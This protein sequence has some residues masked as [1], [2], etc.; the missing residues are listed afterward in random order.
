[1]TRSPYFAEHI[2]RLVRERYGADGLMKRGLHVETT[3]LPLV[4]GIAYENVDFSTRKQDRRQG[5]RGPE[6]HL[7]GAARDTFLERQ[8]R[9]YGE[10]RIAP[11]TRQLAIVDSVDAARA[12]VRVAGNVYTIPLRNMDWAAKWSKNDST[13]DQKITAASQALRVGDV[14]SI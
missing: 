3:V 12:K 6:A 7:E 1:L 2:R 14:V 4:D 5:W 13:N 11:G 8:S 10:A 9:R